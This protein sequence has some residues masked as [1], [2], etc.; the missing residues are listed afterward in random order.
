MAVYVDDMAAEFGR[1]IM[2]HMIA[3]STEE[4]LEMVSKIGV[5][6]K[7]IQFPETYK[8]HFDI[9]KSKRALAIKL[10]A[11]EITWRQYGEMVMERRKR[12]R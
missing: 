5:D 9:A 10:G 1:M 6:P 7:W 4:L 12:I 11:V 2:Y 8:E 3:D